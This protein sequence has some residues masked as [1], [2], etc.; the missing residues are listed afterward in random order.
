MLQSRACF[1]C[2]RE[3]VKV[4]KQNRGVF[5]VNLEGM[6]GSNQ[7]IERVIINTKTHPVFVSSPSQVHRFG[8]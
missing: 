4:K 1:T 6:S 3:E 8:Q 5:S 7:I 2:M